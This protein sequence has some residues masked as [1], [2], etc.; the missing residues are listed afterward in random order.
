MLFRLNKEKG[1]TL[2]IVTHDDEL[3]AKCAR[4]IELKDGEVIA[5]RRR[6]VPS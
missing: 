3:A 6:S 2:I 1:I 5:D 4:V